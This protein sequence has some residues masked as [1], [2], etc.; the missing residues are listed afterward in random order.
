M[1]AAPAD[2]FPA[3]DDPLALADWRRR[4]QDLYAR[5]RAAPDPEAGWRL[6]RAA[7]AALMAGHPCSPLPPARRADLVPHWDHDPALRF[8]VDVVPAEGAP[9]EAVD[10]GADGRLTRRAL[11]RTEGLADR[12]GAELTVWWIGGY[13]GGAFVP[14][15]DAT[16]GAE[17]YGGGRY[18]LDALKGADLGAEGGRLILDFNFAYQPSCAWDPRWTCPLAPPENRLPARVEAGERLA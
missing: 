18:A 12:L 4:V 16:A 3:P 10:L 1:S 6:W 17:T 8:A 5:V 2:P 7:R 11:G 15:V 9:E 13:G 14:F